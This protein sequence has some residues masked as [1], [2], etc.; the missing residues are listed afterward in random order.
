MIL[1]LTEAS[2]RTV[3]ALRS[4]DA[5]KM[6]F[7]KH[8]S[9]GICQVF[10]LHLFTTK[11]IVLYSQTISQ[12]CARFLRRVCLLAG[13]RDC[14]RTFFITLAS[15][16][17]RAIDKRVEDEHSFSGTIRL[18]RQIRHHFPKSEHDL[19]PSLGDSATTPRGASF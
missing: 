1:Y 9:P 4:Q 19:F 17:L 16:E 18:R 11:R 10:V 15:F 6:M 3:L 13:P 8:Q 2:L 7:Y 5:M 14:A 12:S